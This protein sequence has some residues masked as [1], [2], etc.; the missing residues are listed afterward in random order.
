MDVNGKLALVT[1]GSDGIGREVA[2]QLKAAGA[3]V[4]VTGRSAEKLQAMAALGQVHSSMAELDSL[5][6]VLPLPHET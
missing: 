3:E 5:C 1:G 6:A 4:V 2:L